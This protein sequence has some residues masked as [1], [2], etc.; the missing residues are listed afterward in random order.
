VKILQIPAKNS[1]H[2]LPK[3]HYRP[4][5][6]LPPSHIKV[7][8][9]ETLQRHAN[10]WEADTRAGRPTVENPNPPIVRTFPQRQ[11]AAATTAQS[12]KKVAA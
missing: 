6:R 12:G 3:R 5:D 10:R 7:N 1:N 9:M 11:R 2:S 8:A 4:G